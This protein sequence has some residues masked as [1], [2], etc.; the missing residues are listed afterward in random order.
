[1]AKADDP[2]SSWAGRKRRLKPTAMR[3][4]KVNAPQNTVVSRAAKPEPPR[5]WASA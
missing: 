5:S 1:M 2:T 3:R 4:P